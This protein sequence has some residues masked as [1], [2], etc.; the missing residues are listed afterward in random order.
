MHHYVC[1]VY[2]IL[3]A[4]SAP[5][6]HATIR[7]LAALVAS[8]P[9]SDSQGFRDE[10]ETVRAFVLLLLPR[11]T[12][13]QEYVDVQLTAYLSTLTKSTSILNDVCVFIFHS[14]MSSSAL[15]RLSINTISCTLV[16]RKNAKATSFLAGGE[17]CMDAVLS[18]IGT[19]CIE[20]SVLVY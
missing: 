12:P 1:V 7:S 19:G 11:L 16:G 2:R 14:M 13:R 17:V 4:G 18:T 8:L 20:V 3:I 10:F 6:D 9:A 15:R 5:K